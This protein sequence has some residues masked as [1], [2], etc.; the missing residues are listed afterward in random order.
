VTVGIR[1]RFFLVNTV[2]G[3][4]VATLVEPL[5]LVGMKRMITDVQKFSPEAVARS[6]LSGAATGTELDT[7]MFS[8]LSHQ[9]QLAKKDEKRSS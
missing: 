1:L 9:S 7:N 5:G 2:V 3:R 8:A 4:P 6:W